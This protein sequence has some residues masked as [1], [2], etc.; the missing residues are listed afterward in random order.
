MS[1]KRIS[2]DVLPFR[3][4]WES[5][6]PPSPPS[7]NHYVTYLDPVLPAIVKDD[8][9]IAYFRFQVRRSISLG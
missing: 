8:L 1:N 5:Q 6:N 9:N 4:F 2:E 7:P 3:D